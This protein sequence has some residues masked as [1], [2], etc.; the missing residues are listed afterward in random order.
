MPPI[1][2]LYNDFN[3]TFISST[4]FLD[5]HLFL[6]L[7]RPTKISCSLFSFF[8]ALLADHQAEVRAPPVIRGPQVE[9]RCVKMCTVVNIATTIMWII[10]LSQ[11][12]LVDVH[13]LGVSHRD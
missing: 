5:D 8:K 7:A 11:C 10:K 13:L 1:R 3:V 6:D 12:S 2:L 4:K 9:N